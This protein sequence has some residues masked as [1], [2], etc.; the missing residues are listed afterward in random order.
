MAIT[1][2]LIVLSLLFLSMGSFALAVT[3]T[4]SLSNNFP[5]SIELVLM[6][7]VFILIPLSYL[8]FL[9]SERHWLRIA[10]LN[11]TITELESLKAKGNSQ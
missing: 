1:I 8:L 11:E 3:L 4:Q 6:E 2:S 10:K 9:S 5:L 7:T